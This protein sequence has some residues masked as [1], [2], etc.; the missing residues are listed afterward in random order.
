MVFRSGE[1]EIACEE[2]RVSFIC[3]IGALQ[4]APRVTGLS[5]FAVIPGCYFDVLTDQITVSCMAL[6]TCSDNSVTSARSNLP[7]IE[8]LSVAFDNGFLDESEMTKRFVFVTGHL[9]FNS[10]CL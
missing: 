4:T 10:S 6:R 5:A 1:R 7:S 9:P 2:G 3:E 8:D